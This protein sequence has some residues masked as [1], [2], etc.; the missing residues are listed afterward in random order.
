M[1]K[2]IIMQKIPSLFF[3][4]ES[5]KMKGQ[6]RDIGFYFQG[7]EA[8]FYNI[9]IPEVLEQGLNKYPRLETI[10]MDLGVKARPNGWWVVGYQVA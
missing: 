10:R 1:L 8:F 2:H 3:Q 9:T 4:S 7:G 6:P 5:L